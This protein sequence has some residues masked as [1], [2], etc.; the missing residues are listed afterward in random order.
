MDTSKL[1][2]QHN[3]I[4][5]ELRRDPTLTNIEIGERLGGKSARTIENQ[6]AAI[7]KRVGLNTVQ[8]MDKRRIRLVLMLLDIEIEV[9]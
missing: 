5:D 3:R 4:L 2:S 7:Y 6:L 8:P 1:T 9:K